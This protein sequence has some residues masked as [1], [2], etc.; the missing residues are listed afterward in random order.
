[1]A[2]FKKKQEVVEEVQAEAPVAEEVKAEEK[3]K[4]SSKFRL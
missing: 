1:M 2:K 3:K 4:K